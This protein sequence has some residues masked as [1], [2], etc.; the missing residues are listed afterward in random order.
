MNEI[1][2]IELCKQND[3]AAQKALYGMHKDKLYTI[4]YRITNDFD[5]ASDILQLAF[6]DAFKGLAQLQEPKFFYSW[7]KK[8]V[9]RKAYSQVTKKKESVSLDAENAM[10]VISAEVGDVEYIE[11]AIQTLPYKARTV[12]VM[13]EIEGYKHREIAEALGITEGTSKSQLN[14]AKTKLKNLL[15]EYLIG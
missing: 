6:I 3:R 1:Q 9:I 8:M 5:A 4:A 13:A 15:S 11:Q 12:F 14:Y 10:Q 2:L 7:I